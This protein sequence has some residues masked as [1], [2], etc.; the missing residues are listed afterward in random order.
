MKKMARLCRFLLEASINHG[1]RSRTI[2]LLLFAVFIL[3]MA[4]GALAAEREELSLYATSAVLM[5]GESGRVLYGKA[6]REPMANASTTKIMTCILVLEH[7]DLE[8]AL[9]ISAYAEKMP[10]VK[11]GARRGEEYDVNSLLHS[12][13]L[14]S[15]N[16]SAVSL[17]EHVGR[18]FVPEL[19]G[20]AE[21]DFT[22]EESLLALKAFSGLM[23]AKASE[24]GCEDTYFITPNGLDA[25]ESVTL[26]D[27][28]ALIREH[29]TTAADLAMILSYCILD[30]PK[31]VEFL[32][33]TRQPSYAF[34]ANGRSFAFNNHNGFL[35]MM[36]GALTG[37]TGFTGKAGY[38]YA[39]ALVR[40]GRLYVV[41]LLACGWPNNRTYKW[42]DTRKLM[43]FGLAAY[44][45]RETLERI[46]VKEE[47]LPVI[48]VKMGQGQEI[49]KDATLT[50][51]VQARNEEGSHAA[52]PEGLME[53]RGIL[54]A[55]DETLERSMELP[56]ELTAPVLAGQKI[57]SITYRAGNTILYEEDVTAASEVK[58]IDLAW[59]L[60]QVLG[61]YVKMEGVWK[62]QKKY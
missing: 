41:A 62:W 15:H 1:K 12:L 9:T 10:K 45:K 7:C 23:N 21:K 60:R 48:H 52:R 44:P 16:D 8:E 18:A 25:T 13:M 56:K 28:T 24:I 3:S 17:A 20:K 11:L 38:C 33:I 35:S 29:H 46:L 37:K 50:L 42:K 58:E 19:N 32:K 54:L 55:E 57:G 53:G 49:G 30:S 22:M 40:D 5:D 36:E 47:E 31:N 4:R 14:E 61:I 43:E 2:H 51:C 34:C 39:G 26:E 59:C 27:G 6:E